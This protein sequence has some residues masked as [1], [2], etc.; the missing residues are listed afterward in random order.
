MRNNISKNSIFFEEKKLF[1]NLDKYLFILDTNLNSNLKLNEVD[2]L[3]SIIKNLINFGLLGKKDLKIYKAYINLYS[4]F[5]SYIPNKP[6]E[7]LEKNLKFIKIFY[8]QNS[9]MKYNNILLIINFNFK[10]FENLNNFI[11]KLYKNN[12]PNFVFI[13]P[14][15]IINNKNTVLCK[16]S[17]QRYFSYICLEKVFIKYPNY[18]GYLFI[19]DDIFMKTWELDT[20]L[21]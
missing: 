11:L 12:F 3:F 21:I 15:E 19:N 14:S 4:E 1:Y 13:M 6:Y 5:N 8:H 10:G 16:E 20:F 18:K 2:R 9:L 7:F 17:Y